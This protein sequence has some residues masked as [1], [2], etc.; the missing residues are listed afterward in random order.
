MSAAPTA[1]PSTKP[2]VPKQGQQQQQKFKS[3]S[4]IDQDAAAAGLPPVSMTPRNEN[5][6]VNKK[7]GANAKPRP[8]IFNYDNNADG[9]NQN[10]RGSNSN[11]SPVNNRLQDHF[12]LQP[13]QHHKLQQMGIDVKKNNFMTDAEPPAAD[14]YVNHQVFVK[15]PTKR[16]DSIQ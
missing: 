7:P 9:N 2:Q 16:D 4:I 12:G 13:F 10:N 5:F 1:A 3:P 8:D 6:A 15:Q 14:R 11:S